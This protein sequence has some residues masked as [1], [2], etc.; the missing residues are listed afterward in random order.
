MFTS[1]PARL[2]TI[3][4]TTRPIT[5]SI[6]AAARMVLPT[7]E[8]SLPISLR[9][10]TVMETEVAVRMVPMKM[11]CRIRLGPA[12]SGENRKPSRA[13]SPRGTS[14]PIS[15]T[16]KPDFPAFFSSWMSVVIPA[17]NMMTMTP[18]SERWLKK[19]VGLR[20]KGSKKPGR[21]RMLNSAGP[22]MIP[23]ISAPTTWG[24]CSFRVSSPK[25]FVLSKISAMS[26]K[27]RYDS[28]LRYPF[29]A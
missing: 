25:I 8:L 12:S 20:K 28:T 27:N 4:S 23:A 26:Y 24:I 19:S 18:I 15:A 3:V 7:L 2:V 13:P 17:L 22:K 5:S 6:S 14:T 1:A 16:R 10:S 21:C 11:C 9:V 29:Q